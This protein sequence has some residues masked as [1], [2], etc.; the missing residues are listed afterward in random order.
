MA[1]DYSR[2]Q[3]R[4]YVSRQCPR[5]MLASPVVRPVAWVIV[6]FGVCAANGAQTVA[7]DAGAPGGKSRLPPPGAVARK[8]VPIEAAPKPGNKRAPRN[9]TTSTKAT[10]S[11]EG[12]RGRLEQLLRASNAPP[13]DVELAT[14]GRAVDEGLIAIASDPEVELPVRTRAVGALAYTPT[15]TARTYLMSLLRPA[16]SAPAVTGGKAGGAQTAGA[17]KT[18]G[19]PTSKA[20]GATGNATQAAADAGAPGSPDAATTARP[21]TATTSTA[22]ALV[23]LRRAA[24]TIG[25]VGGPLAPPALGPLLEHADPDVR[26]DAAVGLALTR[27]PAAA[28]LLRARLSRETDPRVRGHLT[29]QLSVIDTA[30]ATPPPTA[31]TLPAN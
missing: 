30:L 31:T 26:A 8:L 17:N 6:I 16:S 4:G 29:R 27:L 7:A 10:T 24:V 12:T 5:R 18:A 22:A 2:N 15:R 23:L 28:R 25:W 19:A 3:Q 1:R 21:P 13:T 20:P 9:T 11:G 14:A